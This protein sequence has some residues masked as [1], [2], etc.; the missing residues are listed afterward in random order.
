MSFVLVSQFVNKLNQSIRLKKSFISTKPSKFII[1]L[2]ILLQREGVISNFFFIDY[3][4]LEVHLRYYQGKPVVSEILLKSKPS[5]L[6]YKSYRKLKLDK[7][8]TIYSNSF[9]LGVSHNGIIKTEDLKNAKLK[10]INYS[11]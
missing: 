1:K 2:C 8:P 9:G 7:L 5:L 10:E 11:V 3:N 6:K 4:K